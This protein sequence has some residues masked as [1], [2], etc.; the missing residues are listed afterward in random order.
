MQS[1]EMR[2]S[3]QASTSINLV[4]VD[5]VDDKYSEDKGSE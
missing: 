5:S 3:S 1:M 4:E 2:L